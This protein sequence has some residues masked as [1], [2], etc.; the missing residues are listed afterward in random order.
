MRFDLSTALALALA[1]SALALAIAQFSSSGESQDNKG[2]CSDWRFSY[3]FLSGKP[4]QPTNTAVTTKPPSTKPPI[5]EENDVCSVPSYD[6]FFMAPDKKTYALRG[7][8]FWII[9]SDPGAG[10]DSGPH[11][12][13][14]LWKE[15]PNH[16]DAAYMKD[17]SRLVFFSGSK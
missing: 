4:P 13:T 5:P 11:K 7:S 14:E 2:R 6:T 15:L 17:T 16:I 8:Q 3:I 9:S 10:L 1:H 12:V